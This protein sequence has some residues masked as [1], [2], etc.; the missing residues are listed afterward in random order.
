MN[1]T[2]RTLPYTK[3]LVFMALFDVLEQEHSEYSKSEENGTVTAAV[4]VYGNV[5]EFS[6]EI[7][8]NSPATQMT[9]CVTSP[10]KGLSEQGELRAADFIADRVEQLLEN[11]LKINALLNAGK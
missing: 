3:Q 9:V 4:N 11:E 10:Q 7:K 6:V 8:E 5:S 1:K 2:I